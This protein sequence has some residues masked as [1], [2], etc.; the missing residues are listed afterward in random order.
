MG[1]VLVA[2]APITAKALPDTDIV[3][4]STDADEKPNNLGFIDADGDNLAFFEIRRFNLAPAFPAW[5]SDGNFLLFRGLHDVSSTGNLFAATRDGDVREYSPEFT[6]GGDGSAVIEDGRYAVVHEAA[7]PGGVER[8]VMLDLASGQV[9]RTYVTETARDAYLDCG[10][11]PLHDSKLVYSHLTP[12][13]TRTHATV[14]LLDLNT[15]EQHPLVTGEMM[16]NPAISPDGRWVAYTAR[17]GIHLISSSGEE[18]R[19]IVNTAVERMTSTG[20]TWVYAPPASSWSADSKWIVYRRC[21]QPGRDWCNDAYIKS[22]YLRARYYAPYLNQ[23]IQPDTIV[24]RPESPQD[25]NQYSYARNNP[26]N[27]VDP[28]GRCIPGYDCPGDRPSPSRPP[29]LAYTYTLASL[30]EFYQ[31]QGPNT[32]SCGPTNLA[33]ILT[34]RL[35]TQGIDF[36]VSRQ[37]LGDL[38]LDAS[39][40]LGHLFGLAGYRLAAIAPGATPPWGMEKAFDEFNAELAAAGLPELGSTE[41]DY[42]GTKQDLISNLQSGDYSTLILVYETGPP[43]KAHYVTVVGYESS[44]DTVL[45]LDPARANVSTKPPEERIRS[46][47][48]SDLNE[49]WSRPLFWLGLWHSNTLI[50]THPANLPPSP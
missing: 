4:Q 9:E 46:M 26:V 50:V 19:H 17:D 36:Q 11:N 23:F 34:L 41:Y 42:G 45:L 31:Y 22:I 37:E 8:I 20:P 24:P 49:A 40:G 25:W 12:E 7:D 2:C 6:F 5:A 43:G 15:G 47:A 16:V 44:T 33:M 21:T 48:W 30:G 28:S 18:S 32:R 35:H 29:I 1:L 38:M 3:F 14:T 27:L 13:G 39:Q 10:A